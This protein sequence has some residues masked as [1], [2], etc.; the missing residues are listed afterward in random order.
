MIPGRRAEAAKRVG[1]T[2]MTES[3]NS[4]AS[5]AGYKQPCGG[6]ICHQINLKSLRKT[7]DAYREKG[8]ISGDGGGRSM[9][10]LW[11]KST[12]WRHEPT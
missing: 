2:V 6:T 11:K 1:Q 4:N 12:K 7:I 10:A 5:N 9:E 8:T 3:R